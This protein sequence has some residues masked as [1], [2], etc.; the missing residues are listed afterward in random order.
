[1]TL[2]K[3]YYPS[4]AGCNPIHAVTDWCKVRRIMRAARSNMPIPDVLVDGKN[5]NMLTGTHRAAAR[6]ILIELG[7]DAAAKNIDWTTPDQLTMSAE[8]AEELSE[9]IDASDFER[10]DSLVD[11]GHGHD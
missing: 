6:E 3:Q 5:G 4:I 9:A 10:I 11:R 1:M 2:P 7:D 8:T